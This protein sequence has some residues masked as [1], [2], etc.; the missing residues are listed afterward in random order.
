[1]HMLYDS[2]DFVVLR[3]LAEHPAGALDARPMPRHGF[4]IVDKRAAKKCIWMAL[5][6]SFSNKS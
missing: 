6:P 3:L 4:E 5:G 1:M 2:D